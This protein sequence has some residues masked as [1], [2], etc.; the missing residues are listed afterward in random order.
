MYIGDYLYILGED[1]IVVLNEKDWTEVNKLEMPT[2]NDYPIL[3]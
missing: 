3:Y 2:Y 1:K